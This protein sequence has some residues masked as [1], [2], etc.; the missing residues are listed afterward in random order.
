MKSRS[1]ERVRLQHV[2]LGGIIY[3]TAAWIEE[4]GRRLV[5]ADTKHFDLGAQD[6]QIPRPGRAMTF[7]NKQRE[8]HLDQVQRELKEAGL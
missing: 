1:G 3:T 6:I 2:R 5:D 4:F 8:A 7:T